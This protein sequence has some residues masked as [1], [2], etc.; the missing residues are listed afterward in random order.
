MGR[1]L[2]FIRRC[3]P[4]RSPSC[5]SQVIQAIVLCHVDFSSM[6]WS[7]A[8]KKDLRKLHLVQNREERS[9]LGC[10]IRACRDKMHAD[11]TWRDGQLSFINFVKK[12]NSFETTI[13]FVFKN[14]LFW[15]YT[16]L[17]NKAGEE[18]PHYAASTTGQSCENIPSHNSLEQFGVF[19]ISRIYNKR[20]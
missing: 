18:G 13:M 1:G 9:A 17:S 4:C 16:Q 12:F 6:I 3:S 20:F 11:C 2:S 8:A 10:S 5:T 7:S 19:Y 15:K 14:I